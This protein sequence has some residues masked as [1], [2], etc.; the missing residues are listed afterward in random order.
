[1]EREAFE[2][3]A[4]AGHH[5]YF[6]R[7]VYQAV[8]E[9]EEE[10]AATGLEGTAVA[11]VVPLLHAEEESSQEM[12]SADSKGEELGLYLMA[13]LVQTKRGSC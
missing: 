5:L 4:L 8:L 1:M 7:S 10:E 13:G 6:H 9:E 3:E 2:A 12:E 11:V